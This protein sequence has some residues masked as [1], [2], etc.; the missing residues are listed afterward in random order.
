[1]QTDNVRKTHPMVLVAAVAITIFSL[2][3]S[4]VITGLIP[5]A[6]SERQSAVIEQLMKQS[7]ISNDAASTTTQAAPSAR[8]GSG[9]SYITGYR[10]KVQ[11]Q[12]VRG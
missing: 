9:S 10:C 12:G 7:T 11:P 4:A 2:L 6:Y 3:G 1:M 5:N 8:S